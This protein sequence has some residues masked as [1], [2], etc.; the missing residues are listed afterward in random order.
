MYPA[1]DL[2]FII[3][4]DGTCTS[5]SLCAALSCIKVLVVCKQIAYRVPTHT[6]RVALLPE[7]LIFYVLVIV[8][9]HWLLQ[10]DEDDHQ[11]AA[12]QPSPAAA[13]DLNTA[14]T[15]EGSS[16][17]DTSAAATAAANHHAA[18]QLLLPASITAGVLAAK[19]VSCAGAA[20]S[21]LAA[22][23]QQQQKEWREEEK[24][25]MQP[26]VSMLPVMSA[27]GPFPVGGMAA[28][29][30]VDALRAWVQAEA[31]GTHPSNSSSSLLLGLTM[32]QGQALESLYSV[33]IM[34]NTAAEAGGGLATA[35]EHPDAAEGVGGKYLG[36]VVAAAATAT[37]G[38][39][40]ASEITGFGH[41]M[42]L[43]ALSSKTT[44]NSSGSRSSTRGSWANQPSSTSP[45]EATSNNTTNGSIFVTSVSRPHASSSSS[46]LASG[47]L[48]TSLKVKL[49][50]LPQRLYV[51]HGEHAGAADGAEH[52][53]PLLQGLLSPPTL[54]GITA[55]II[56]SC[57]ALKV[58]TRQ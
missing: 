25:N 27:M 42:G 4:L 29:D 57:P 24:Q 30:G 41:P 18:Q 54:A 51:H 47:Q 10:K 7:S 11:A 34:D 52:M 6:A 23:V 39:G 9:G 33:G 13:I 12:S 35:K 14:A 22:K 56:G 37:S 20:T 26:Q 2:T 55:M 58:S 21:T 8:S 50:R 49:S 43:P 5:L 38:V 19:G 3:F 1:Q 53:H 40:T 15:V 48:S 44:S 17:S 36:P 46:G 31:P 45:D 16:I 32:L 28:A